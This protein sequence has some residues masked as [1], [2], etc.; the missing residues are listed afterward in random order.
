MENLIDFGCFYCWDKKRE[1]EKELFFFD[2]ANNLKLCQYCPVCGRK[3]GEFPEENEEDR[4][5]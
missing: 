4:R 3:Y 1:K 2:H 5:D